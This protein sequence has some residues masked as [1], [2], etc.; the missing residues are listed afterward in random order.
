MALTTGRR[1]K[2]RRF[3]VLGVA[4]V[5]ALTAASFSANPA[6]AKDP[7]APN[8]TN[9]PG[10][11]DKASY[12]DVRNDPAN[13]KALRTKAAQQSAK[14]KFGVAALRKELG[15]QGIVSID[16][17]TGTARSV[18]RLNGFLTGPSNRAAADVARDYVRTHPDVF[19]LDTNGMNRLTLRRDY[20]D[21]GATHHLSF[22]Q[23][24]D[25][26]PVFGNGVQANVAKDGRL[27]NV[28]GSPVAALPSA[29][30]VPGVSAD[31]AR[32]AATAGVEA[33]A[34]PAK[35][36]V[37]GG[38]RR[39][40]TFSTGERAE[41]A[42]FQTLGGLRLA[43]QTLTMPSHKD[44]YTSI[45]DAE[46]GKVL[47]RRSLVS[48]DNGLAWDNYPGAAAG[49]VQRSHDLTNAGWLPN[50]SPRLAGNVAHVYND[51]NDDN[52]AQPTEEI[53][54]S[55][56]RKFN[57]P[58]KDFNSVDPRCTPAFQ[59][60]WDPKTP[61]S[62][63]TNRNQNGV[64]VLYFLGKYHDHLLR[65]PIG[66]TRAAG[67]FEAVD[68]DAV[69]AE[70]MDGSNTAGG[71]PDSNHADNANMATPP[72]GQKPRM[73][74]YLF[75]DPANPADPFIPS[76]GGDE[77]D[78]VYHEYTHGLSNR[79]VVDALGNSTLGNIQ[80]GA[81]GEAW[82]DWYAMNF[83]VKQDF[84]PDDPN[85]PGDVRIGN[86]VGAGNDLIR[87]QPM[88]CPVGTTSTKCPGT[89]GAGPGGYTYGDF[90]HIIGQPEVHADGEI[91]G[92]TLW[93]LR[94]A[95]G[96]WKAESLV[97]RAMELSPANPSFLDMRNGILLAD[98]VLYKGSSNTKLWKAFAKRG[99]GWFAGAVDGDDTAPVE[100]FSM[101]PA[102]NTPTG[103]LSG[104]VTDQDSHAPIAGAVV[105]FGG[106][107]SG[108]PGDYAAVTDATGHYTISGILPGTYPAVFARGNGY[109]RQVTTLS[110]ASRANSRDWSLRRDWAA[111]AGGGSVVAFNGPDFT[112]FGCGPNSAIDQSLGNGW[113]S[114][115]DLTGGVAVPKFVTVKLPRAVNISQVAIDPGNTCGDGGSASTKDWKVE[116]S[117]DGTT[118]VL[119]ASGT[120][121][122]IDRHRLNLVTLAAGTNTGINVIRFTMISPQLPG[123]PSTLCPGP[124]S[125]CL[126]MDMSELEVYGLPAP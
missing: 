98:Q 99:M 19:G 35:A 28:V 27:I 9:R 74:M 7:G 39:T 121:G 79:L 123:D 96:T 25:G 112:G 32:V 21:I 6:E 33:T 59:C 81:M 44:M 18:S 78:V 67:N 31:K 102:P 117:V 114:T 125:G 34:K 17:L 10:L 124:F 8:P 91:W 101:P 105:G 76:N 63:Q 57:F 65:A 94:T 118:F 22:I 93:D 56:P 62:W 46:S 45:V 72:D 36:S 51:A 83:L 126:F 84:Q 64:Q 88:D 12:Y 119:A 80:A 70:I 48:N 5:L 111:L 30:G 103:S 73:Q 53:T 61:N 106:H 90:G 109:D 116:T 77:A 71:L 15:T 47:Y 23:S 97:T 26:V 29:A 50:D 3:L 11:S 66:F 108:F 92:E 38:P 37:Q 41:L 58:F 55:G 2:L 43:W 107:A 42:Y 1:K 87:S 120:F 16:P 69:Q 86:Y 104:V 68:D 20:V 40:T 122:P 13:A 115:S 95:V 100:D 60:S 14:P 49:G 4:P 82:S 24:V 75:S 110:I 85:V 113:G 89:P 54:P 52:T